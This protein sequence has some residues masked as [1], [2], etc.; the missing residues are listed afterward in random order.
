VRRRTSLFV[1]V[2]T[3]AAAAMNAAANVVPWPGS[4]KPYLW[5]AWPVLGFLLL[6]V[7]I[8]EVIERRRGRDGQDASRQSVARVAPAVAVQ[9]VS[10]STGG[11]AQGAMFGNIVNH[12]GPGTTI[13]RTSSEEAG[14]AAGQAR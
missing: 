4:W 12:A 10:A 1:V 6:V 2:G 3:V 13:A 14:D 11:T 9:Q 5:A 8:V 7:V